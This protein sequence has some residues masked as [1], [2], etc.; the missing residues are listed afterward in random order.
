M[1]LSGPSQTLYSRAPEQ[2][3]PEMIE[4]KTE[5][6]FALASQFAEQFPFDVKTAR[7]RGGAMAAFSNPNKNMGFTTKFVFSPDGKIHLHAFLEFVGQ[8][9]DMWQ[10]AQRFMRGMAWS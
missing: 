6:C 1:N 10:V 8:P 3:T 5:E 4:A 7:F 2:V 9:G